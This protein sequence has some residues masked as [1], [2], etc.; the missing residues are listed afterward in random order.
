MRVGFSPPFARWWAKAHPTSGPQAFQKD[1]AGSTAGFCR[2]LTSAGRTTVD[3]RIAAFELVKMAAVG[4]TR[5]PDL[6]A[7]VLALQ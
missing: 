7:T 6:R 4:R 3:G 1:Q 5:D 2:S